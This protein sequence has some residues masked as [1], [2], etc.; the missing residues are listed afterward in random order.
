MSDPVQLLQSAL[1]PASSAAEAIHQLTIVLT[2]GACAILVLVG[3]LAVYGALSGPRKVS[4]G[5]WVIGGGVVFPV[6]VLA[7]LLVHALRVGHALSAPPARPAEIE[8]TGKMWWWEVRYLPP[9]AGALPGDVCTAATRAAWEPPRDSAAAAVLA[10]E[11]YIPV[12]RPVEIALKSDSVIHSFWVPALAG[13][14]DMIPGRTTRI[15]VQAREPG[16]Y[17]GQCAEYCGIQHSW[18]AFH[19]VAVPEEEYRQWLASQAAP[20]PEPGSAFLRQGR[21][22]FFKGGCGAC[23][24]VRGTAAQGTLGPDLT[25]VGSRRSIAAGRLDNHAGTLA[26]W[27][28]DSQT[29][30]PGNLMPSTTVYSGEELRAVAAWLESLK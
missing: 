18:M 30:K 23:H 5:A 12:G 28:A 3:A 10:N 15:V 24:A 7:A 11:I 26:G 2:V 8:V 4:T 13:K 25:H 14:V 1:H 6:V 27:I 22:A 20:A 16:V 17:R 29:I 19:V 21:E 9:G